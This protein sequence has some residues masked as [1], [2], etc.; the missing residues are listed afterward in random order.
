MSKIGQPTKTPD[1]YDKP[2]PSAAVNDQLYDQ[3]PKAA[4]V[5]YDEIAP[6]PKCKIEVS[7]GVMLADY[8]PK[9]IRKP[10]P[11]ADETQVSQVTSKVSAHQ[12]CEYEK[13]EII[14]S[15]MMSF[16][17][18]EQNK[19]KKMRRGKSVVGAET[20]LQTASAH[21]KLKK[22]VVVKNKCCIATWVVLAFVTLAL[23]MFT[24]LAAFCQLEETIP[25][26]Y[27]WL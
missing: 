17:G 6:G 12:L 20:K 27:P 1:L 11:K 23:A 7:S 13:D 8:T 15:E 3:P 2:P 22:K 26:E 24:S 16:M 14:G 25:E 9:E 10:T 4:E 5:N 21:P 19:R 18:S